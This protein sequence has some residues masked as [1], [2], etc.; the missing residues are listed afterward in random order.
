LLQDTE[1][2]D[3]YYWR[4]TGIRCHETRELF[5]YLMT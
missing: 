3:S 5:Q 4:E 2:Q 1:I